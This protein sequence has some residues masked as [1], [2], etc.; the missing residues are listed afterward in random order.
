MGMDLANPESQ[1]APQTEKISHLVL[2]DIIFYTQLPFAHGLGS[3]T[4][5][6]CVSNLVQGTV[7]PP[8]V[9]TRASLASQLLAPGND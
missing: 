2:Q 7:P 6:Y 8:F 3:D 1:E 9:F 5:C 4:C